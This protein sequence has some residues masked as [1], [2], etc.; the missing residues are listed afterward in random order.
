MLLRRPVKTLL[1]VLG[2]LL[3]AGAAALAY[4][5]RVDIAYELSRLQNPEAGRFAA[6]P[7]TLPRVHHLFDLGVVDADGDG[8]L[9]VFTSNHNYRQVLLLSDGRGG[10][11]DV[12]TEWGLDQ[13]RDFP[14]WEQS[15]AAPAMDKPGLYVYWLGETLVLRTHGAAGRVTGTLKMFSVIDVK[16][17]DGF[18]VQ[19]R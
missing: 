4:K 11:R 18:K 14:H 7:F 19:T 8:T 9:D 6:E 1:I 12:L 10:H 15:F 5:S 13:N 2:L 17:A 16:R 3:L